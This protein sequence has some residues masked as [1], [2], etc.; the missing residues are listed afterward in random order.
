MEPKRDSRSIAMECC[1]TLNCAYI[2]PWKLCILPDLANSMFGVHEG[3]DDGHS[4][5]SGHGMR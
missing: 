3:L 4:G 1:E 2:E 5:C